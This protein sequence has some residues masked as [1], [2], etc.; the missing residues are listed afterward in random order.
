PSTMGSWESSSA[1]PPSRETMRK[2]PWLVFHSGTVS[3]GRRAEKSTREESD[4]AAAAGGG[5]C[6]PVAVLRSGSLSPVRR[7]FTM[8]IPRSSATR[9][10]PAACKIHFARKFTL[11]CCHGMRK[12]ATPHPPTS[13][14]RR[15][16]FRRGNR[17][18]PR[19]FKERAF[20]RDGVRPR[21]KIVTNRCGLVKRSLEM[22]LY[23][24]DEQPQ[25]DDLDPKDP[26]DFTAL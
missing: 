2:L 23:S 6:S 12:F 13:P 8:T 14:S 5:A 22:H 15:R 9:S 10:G 21:T 20:V 3:P 25:N 4:A 26:G 19:R 11:N 18:T 24:I 17:G 7:E 16:K 1:G